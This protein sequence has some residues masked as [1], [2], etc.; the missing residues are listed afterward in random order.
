MSNRFL[1]RPVHLWCIW[2]CHN[3]S[4]KCEI[5]FL[6]LMF[7]R[8]CLTSH[9]IG[10]DV[11]TRR[12]VEWHLSQLF[13]SF[14]YFDRRQQPCPGSTNRHSCRWWWR[15]WR[16]FWLDRISSARVV[17]TDDELVNNFGQWHHYYWS[18]RRIPDCAEWAFSFLLLETYW[19]GLQLSLS[20]LPMIFLLKDGPIATYV[21]NLFLLLFI[22]VIESLDI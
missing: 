4:W 14:I 17:A 15:A 11:P 16:H 3:A 13:V 10:R 20:N 18:F 19:E 12:G 8:P 2:Y 7:I 21:F 1:S 9:F 5:P 22:N 6:A